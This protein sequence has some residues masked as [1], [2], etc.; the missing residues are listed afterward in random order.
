MNPN[1][2]DNKHLQALEKLA[3]GDR[4]QVTFHQFNLED[5]MEAFMDLN[6]KKKRKKLSPD[7]IE[8]HDRIYTVL[9]SVFQL[10]AECV[11][12]SDKE[13]YNTK[14]IKQIVRLQK[15]TISKDKK[16]ISE[17]NRYVREW[18]KYEPGRF[19]KIK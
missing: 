7:E 4:W 15:L 11:A 13:T 17:Y 5:I 2:T 8:L 3:E 14:M 6:K 19:V 16:I 1:R 10:A 12:W 9:P 18:G